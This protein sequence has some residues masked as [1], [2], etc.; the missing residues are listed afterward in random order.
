MVHTTSFER[1]PFLRARVAS[2][3]RAV[4]HFLDWMRV[5]GSVMPA[6]ALAQFL[7]IIDGTFAGK[8]GSFIDQNA[9]IFGWVHRISA[10]G[11]K[12][13]GGSHASPRRSFERTTTL[14]RLLHAAPGLT[15]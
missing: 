14:Y 7:F 15:R 9:Y 2:V 5:V 8:H 1:H 13:F 6:S 10:H 12:I 3:W 11:I 4:R